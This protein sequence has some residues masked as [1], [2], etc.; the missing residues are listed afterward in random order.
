MEGGEAGKVQTRWF[1]IC[2]HGPTWREL[3]SSPGREGVA[4]LTEVQAIFY[5]RWGNNGKN[6]MYFP[7][8]LQ[9]YHR[10]YVDGLSP[11]CPTHRRTL[12]G[13]RTRV[14][15]P[16][17]QASTLRPKLPQQFARLV[18]SFKRVQISGV[19]TQVSKSFTVHYHFTAILY[20]P[21]TAAASSPDDCPREGS[22]L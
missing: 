22:T 15:R 11:A 12:T 4:G 1:V 17:A 8:K 3:W 9:I 6:D 2:L 10:I 7:D 16:Q 13:S 21:R 14:G 19:S 5:R 18:S 20:L